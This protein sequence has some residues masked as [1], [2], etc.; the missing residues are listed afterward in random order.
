MK[1]VIVDIQ[2]LATFPS[3]RT[4]SD[5]AVQNSELLVELKNGSGYSRVHLNL[6]PGGIG[7]ER[8]F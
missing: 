7:M 3:C 8:V 5:N 1:N 6:A 4:S 2:K